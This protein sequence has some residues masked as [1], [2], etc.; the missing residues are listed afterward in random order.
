MRGSSCG[1]PM[2][3]M[4]NLSV[5]AVLLSLLLPLCPSRAEEQL[6]GDRSR[7]SLNVISLCSLFIKWIIINS[8]W[9][10]FHFLLLFIICADQKS[11]F[12]TKSD[13]QFRVKYSYIEAPL[14]L[15]QN[16]PPHPSLFIYISLTCHFQAFEIRQPS[17]QTGSAAQDTISQSPHPVYGGEEAWKM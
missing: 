14:L 12:Y 5:C 8:F 6:A 1:I 2:Q 3:M 16:T 10:W 17:W 4:I 9:A 7:R 11:G 15:G 13:L